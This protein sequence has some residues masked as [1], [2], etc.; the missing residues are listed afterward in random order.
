MLGFEGIP[1]K[2]FGWRYRSGRSK[3]CLKFK[4]PSAPAAIKTPSGH[5]AP[6]PPQG[7]FPL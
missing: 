7:R 2:R 4:N 5:P 3:D 6:S 1:S